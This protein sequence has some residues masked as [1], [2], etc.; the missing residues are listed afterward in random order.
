[1]ATPLAFRSM[2]R[3]FASSALKWECGVSVGCCV[4]AN[5]SARVGSNEDNHLGGWH[6]YR[7]SKSALNQH[8][9]SSPK[10]AFHEFALQKL[11]SFINNAKRQDNGK[12]FACDGQEIPW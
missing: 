4:V 8:M 10:Q 6:S 11:L 3:G 1:M 7:S 5:L 12:L 2:R 9:I